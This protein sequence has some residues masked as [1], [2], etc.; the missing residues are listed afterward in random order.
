MLKTGIIGALVTVI[1]CFTS[2]IGPGGAG[3]ITVAS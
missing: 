3:M 1:L 2:V